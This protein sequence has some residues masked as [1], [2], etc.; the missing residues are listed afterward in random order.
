LILTHL[1]QLREAF[2][3]SEHTSHTTTTA[4]LKYTHSLLLQCTGLALPPPTSNR[5]L[6]REQPHPQPLVL[7]I[8]CFP[9]QCRYKSFQPRAWQQQKI[10]KRSQLVPSKS[11]GFWQHE[12]V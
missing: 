1:T 10:G 9:L 12:Q 8:Y 2:P 4:L 7:T 6:G 5:E 11:P 3:S